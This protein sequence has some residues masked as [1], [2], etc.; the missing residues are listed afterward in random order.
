MHGKKGK[1]HATI[2]FAELV[3]HSDTVEAWLHAVSPVYLGQPHP[4]KIP[5]QHWNGLRHGTS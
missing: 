2:I 3:F 5:P 1:E 4:E